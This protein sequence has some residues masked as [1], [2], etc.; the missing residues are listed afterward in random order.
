[1]VFWLQ[2]RGLDA[3]RDRAG[4]APHD[5]NRESTHSYGAVEEEEQAR[6]TAKTPRRESHQANLAAKWFALAGAEAHGST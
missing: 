6:Y 4:G 2:C 3:P 5:D 1:M